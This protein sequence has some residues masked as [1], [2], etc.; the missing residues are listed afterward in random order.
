MIAY[1]GP[2][3]ARLGRA[4]FLGQDAVIT[5]ASTSPAPLPT[6]EPYGRTPVAAPTPPQPETQAPPAEKKPWT[7]TIAGQT[8]S[9]WTLVMSG[10]V[11]AGG[12]ALVVFTKEDVD[13]IYA[14]KTT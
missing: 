1:H 14:R 4:P 7:V 11:I 13:K 3:N 9:G 8:I 2:Y 10:L 6:P 12:I 5:P